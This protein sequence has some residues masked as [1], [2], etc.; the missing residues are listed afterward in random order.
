MLKTEELK[1]LDRT[2]IVE[3]EAAVI[4]LIGL[5]LNEIANESSDQ[6]TKEAAER[7]IQQLML[8]TPDND[9]KRDT[10]RKSSLL[11]PNLRQI[12][13]EDIRGQIDY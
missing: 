2:Y 5:T 8:Q 1:G 10:M 12:T 9:I 6:R 13:Y 11:V 7:G 4:R 3:L